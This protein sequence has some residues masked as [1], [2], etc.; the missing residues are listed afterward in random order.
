ME[1]GMFHPGVLYKDADAPVRE[2]LLL[3]LD[4][5]SDNRNTILLAL[6]WIGDE[7]VVSR[8]GEW[9]DNQP[10]WAERLYVAPE[11]YAREAGWELTP[12]G[13]RRDLFHSLAYAIEKSEQPSR[14]EVEG[15]ALFLNPADSNCPWCGGKLD[16]L[17]DV[18]TA[19]PSLSYLNLAEDRLQIQTCVRCGCYGVIYMEYDS[20][21]VP[22]WSR[23]NRIPDYLQDLSPEEYDGEYL[24]AGPLLTLSSQ[25]R[26]AFY[27]TE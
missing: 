17:M 6:S 21:G 1:C 23:F 24:E 20:N 4:W 19:H 10:S 3:R 5:D 16:T 22:G 27:T 14:S 12:E 9:R 13:E 18:D 2:Q 11:M 26:S 8:L 15:G 25:P 7:Q